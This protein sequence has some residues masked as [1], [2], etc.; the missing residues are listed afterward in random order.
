MQGHKKQ[1]RTSDYVTSN[2]NQSTDFKIAYGK[3]KKAIQ[4]E[5]H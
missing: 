1:N 5:F 2:K 4:I 3:T